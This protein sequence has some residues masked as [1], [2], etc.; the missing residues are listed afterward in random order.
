MPL[1]FQTKSHGTVAFGFFNIESDMLLLE[2]LFLFS[3]RFCEYIIDITRLTKLLNHES[4]WEV[5]H[6]VDRA[7]V[8]DL[9]GAIHGLRYS[10][11]I[12]E[13]YR[14]YPFPQDPGLFKQNPEGSDTREV[15]LGI[16]QKF[17]Q[18]VRIRFLIDSADKSVT[19]GDYVFSW[20]IFKD[21]IHYVWLGGYPRWKDGK[22]PGFVMEMKDRIQACGSGLFQDIRFEED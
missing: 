3:D 16:I 7:D 6:I 8:G 19:I 5:Y 9:M 22:R 1:G 18:P 11:F 21:L 12:G 10:G 2:N 20:P 15:I 4:H 17:A 13:V 14:E